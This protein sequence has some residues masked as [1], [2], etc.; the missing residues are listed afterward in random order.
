MQVALVSAFQPRQTSL[1]P[2]E[3]SW[4]SAQCELSDFWMTFPRPPLRERWSPFG[5]RVSMDGFAG[6]H[7]RRAVLVVAGL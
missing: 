7:A 1:D 5:W 4:R 3:L 2:A 6:R